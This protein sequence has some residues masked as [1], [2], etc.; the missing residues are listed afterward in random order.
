MHVYYEASGHDRRE[1]RNQ[2]ERD[3]SAGVQDG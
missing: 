2:S 3:V 1:R